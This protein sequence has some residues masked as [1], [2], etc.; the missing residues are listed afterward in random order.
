MLLRTSKKNISEIA[1]CLGFYDGMYFSK[2]FKKYYSV[3]PSEYRRL[4]GRQE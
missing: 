1:E 4:Y 3:A 2:V